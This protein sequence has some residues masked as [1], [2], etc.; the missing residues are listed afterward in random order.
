MLVSNSNAY[1]D[2][3]TYPG[4]SPG[5]NSSTPRASPTRPDA[6]H[7]NGQVPLTPAHLISCLISLSSP[8][9]QPAPVA[10]L[11]EQDAALLEPL[12][13]KLGQVCSDL[14]RG[15]SSPSSEN[16]QIPAIDHKTLIRLRRRLETATRVLNGELDV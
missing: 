6:N 8:S 13:K 11:S 2:S 5:S 10:S 7:S 9:A 14:V 3:P 4:F 15:P 16:Q 12:L 1:A